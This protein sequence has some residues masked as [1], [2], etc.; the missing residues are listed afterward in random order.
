MNDAEKAFDILLKATSTI[1]ANREVHMQVLKA[2]DII[3]ALVEKTKELEHK[4]N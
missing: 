1:N 3:K 2:L 4:E